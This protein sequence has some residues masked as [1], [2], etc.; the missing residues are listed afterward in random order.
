VLSEY[1]GDRHLEQYVRLFSQLVSV[2][3]PD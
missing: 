2:S 1:V 3:P